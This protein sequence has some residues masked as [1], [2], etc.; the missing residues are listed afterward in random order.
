MSA[1][2]YIGCSTPH[3]RG[4]G[5]GWVDVHAHRI[6]QLGDAARQRGAAG[7]GIAHVEQRAREAVEVVDGVRG[8]LPVT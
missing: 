7:R 6:E 3:A 8:S 1:A 2:G 4:P 5:R